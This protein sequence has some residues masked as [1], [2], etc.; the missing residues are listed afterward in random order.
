MASLGHSSLLKPSVTGRLI[1]TA[2]PSEILMTRLKSLLN[3]A[4]LSSSSSSSSSSLPARYSHSSSK[5]RA[6]ESRRLRLLVSL[7]EF[8]SSS[9]EQI[10][11]QQTKLGIECL[12]R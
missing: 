7:T 9:E 3:W 4:M 8:T 2:K 10:P 12:H 1:L 6:V 11:A 5:V